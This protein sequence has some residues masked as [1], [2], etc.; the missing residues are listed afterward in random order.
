M[1][2]YKLNNNL[3]KKSINEREIIDLQHILIYL[4]SYVKWNYEFFLHKFEKLLKL[5]INERINL[6]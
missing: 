3:K 4:I 2:L 1:C 6:K 5:Y